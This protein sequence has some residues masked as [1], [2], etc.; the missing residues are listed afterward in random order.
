M[1]DFIFD[2]QLLAQHC[3]YGLLHEEMICDCLVAGIHDITLSKML[4]MDY[5]LTLDTVIR[6]VCE[7]ES[8]RQQQKT[9]QQDKDTEVDIVLETTSPSQKWDCITQTTCSVTSVL[10]VWSSSTY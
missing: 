10:Q 9:I 4:Q 7:K 3:Q 5:W 2:V 1:V 8:I 6:K